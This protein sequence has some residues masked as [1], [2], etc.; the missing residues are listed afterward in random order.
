MKIFLSKFA[1]S[2]DQRGRATCPAEFREIL[3]SETYKGIVLLG[4]YQYPAIECFGISVMEK[5]SQKLD[6]ANTYP[7]F[8]M[9]Q[10]D[11]NSLFGDVV[12]CPFTDTAGR[13]IIP[14]HLLEHA[15]ITTEALFVGRG[16]TFQIWDA[17]LFEQHTANSRRR[18]QE[19]CIIK[20]E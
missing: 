20:D 2:I 11:I 8:T 6:N 18:V 13:F 19:R 10:E 16:S 5:M 9:E 3:A 4:S 1:K 12:L 14:K 17:N 7:F 15:K